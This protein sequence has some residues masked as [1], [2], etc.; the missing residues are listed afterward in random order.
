MKFNL[1]VIFVIA[2]T[3]GV[4]IDAVAQTSMDTSVPDAQIMVAPGMQTE[5]WSVAVVYPKSVSHADSAKALKQLALITGWKF[6]APKFEDKR[7][8]DLS[9]KPSGVMSSVSFHTTANLVDYRT[10]VLT[11]EPFLRAYRDLNRV[12]VTYIVP[13]TFVVRSLPSFSDKNIEIALSGQEG[14]FTYTANIKNHELG[15]LNLPMQSAAVSEPKESVA[16]AQSPR[17]L[18]WLSLSLIGL[19]AVLAALLA[20]FVA[21][22]FTR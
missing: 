16:P 21:R 18:P 20:F 12:N 1:A 3:S 5:G 2:L 14:L 7:L 9:G 17:R 22:R 4:A 19:A 10:G 13:G 8:N 6:D 11:L 15:A